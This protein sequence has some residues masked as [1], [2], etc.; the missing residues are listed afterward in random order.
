MIEINLVD[1]L[2]N[3]THTNPVNLINSKYLFRTTKN[4]CQTLIY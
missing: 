3:S 1:F 4:I 2:I